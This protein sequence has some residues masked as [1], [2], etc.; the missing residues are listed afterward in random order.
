MCLL[1]LSSLI[2]QFNK[3]VESSQTMNNGNSRI[4]GTLFVTAGFGALPCTS[5][6]EN[7]RMISD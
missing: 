5:S 3:I 4:E 1:D 7:F 2:F 6:L